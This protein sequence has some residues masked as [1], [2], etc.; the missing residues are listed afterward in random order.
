MKR[1]EPALLTYIKEMGYHPI[2]KV[3]YY[4]IHP[5]QDIPVIEGVFAILTIIFIG[6]IFI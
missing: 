3:D 4:P 2:T 6:G 5:W 1:D